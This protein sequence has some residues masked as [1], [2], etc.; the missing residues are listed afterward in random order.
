MKQFLLCLM[1]FFLMVS[2]A[3]AVEIGQVC[4]MTKGTEA[5]QKFE[6]NPIQPYRGVIVPEDQEIIIDQKISDFD[7]RLLEERMPAERWNE[8]WK[9]AFEGSFL[10]DFGDGQIQTLNILV[11]EEHLKD[12]KDVE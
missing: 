4:T 7:L 5:V 2:I 3:G 8:N 11:R 6:G 12:C 10:Y 1:A 9:T